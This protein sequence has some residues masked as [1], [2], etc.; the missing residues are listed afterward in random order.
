ML[1]PKTIDPT[2][3]VQ[4]N[5]QQGAGLLIDATKE[6]Y[7]CTQDNSKLRL[8]DGLYIVLSQDCDI[9][10]KS[11]EKEPVIEIIEAN[12][13]AQ[14]N[15]EVTS[16]KNPRLLH[17]VIESEN[18]ILEF[19][20]YKRYFI[21]RHYLETISASNIIIKGQQLKILTRWIFKRIV[22][23]AFPDA[24]NRRL[25][26][27]YIKQIKRILGNEAKES[28]G[29]FIRLASEKE[30]S[31]NQTYKVLVIMLVS[32]DI[33]DNEQALSCIE[34]G[35]NQIILILDK[36]KGIE[37]IEGSQVLSLDDISV[38]RY[39]ELKQWDFDFISFSNNEHGNIIE[40]ELI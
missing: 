25:N 33:F 28:L 29:L 2:K 20:P 19:L 21:S 7:V 1:Q 18:S 34:E 40:E 6:V 17:L 31:D 39:Q 27:K 26:Q 14:C 35:F 13:I 22:R 11:L 12:Q 5:W 3:I 16:G 30:L 15:T 10:N 23:S 32:K 8:M 4:N 36:I 37:V 24:F 38:H 9:V